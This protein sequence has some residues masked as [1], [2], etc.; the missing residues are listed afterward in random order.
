[1][2]IDITSELLAPSGATLKFTSEGQIHKI[3]IL[4][5]RK[6]QV[7]DFMTG[8]PATW[9]NGEPKYQYVVSGKSEGEDAK[10]YIKAW[11]NQKQALMEA[12]RKADV[13][14][15]QSLEGGTLTV[16]W[17]STD[18]PVKA[19]LSGAKRFRMKFEPAPKAVLT[20]DDDLI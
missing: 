7:R 19:G 12:L 18:E 10:L 13:Q 20:D 15:G 3:T 2:T 11:G 6:E 14:P 8:E 5:S 16:K 1:M 4:D 9:D 17:D